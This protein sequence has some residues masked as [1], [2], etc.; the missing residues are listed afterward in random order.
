MKILVLG[1]Y[2]QSLVTFRGALI[3][4]M[5][6]NGHEVMASAPAI[7]SGVRR[8]LTE[9]GARCREVNMSRTGMNPVSDLRTLRELYR[10]MRDEQ[11]DVLFAYTVKPVIYGCIAARMAGVR[12]CYPMITGL[13]SAFLGGGGWRQRLVRRVIQC[14]YRFALKASSGIFFQNPDDRD[15][16]HRLGLTGGHTEVIMVNG[17]GVDTSHFAPVTLPAD[18]SFLLIARLLGDKGVR[19]YVEAAR[20]VRK[21]H[22][23]ARFYLAGWLDTNPSAITESELQG[24]VDEGAVEFLGKLDDVRPAISRCQVYVLPSYRE[25]TPRTVLEAMSMGRPV[26]TT[27]APGCRETV[28]DGVN[29]RLVPVGDAAAL[30]QAMLSYLQSPELVA[31]HGAEAR[32]QAETKYDVHKVNAVM[33]DAMGLG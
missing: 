3:R 29:G 32:R 18:P 31:Q 28:K 7:S 12:A 9:W 20:L 22:P 15:E 5:L 6:A 13:G 16:F 4:A 30:S 27:D 26:I 17:S 2:D 24:W 23:N 10:L 11:P 14:L 1:S 19:E 25:G 33:L 21:K 8:E